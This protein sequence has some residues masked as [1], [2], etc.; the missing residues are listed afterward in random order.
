MNVSSSYT[1]ISIKRNAFEDSPW[2][3]VVVQESEL[4]V[5]VQ[6]ISD[7]YDLDG[8]RVFRKKDITTMEK[9]FEKREF[10]EAALRIKG[11]KPLHP[12]QIELS[13][14][15]ALMDSA[16]QQFGVLV[17]SREKLYPG[18]VEVGTVR[19]ASEKTYVLRWL[20]PDA[21]WEN[22]DRPYRLQD[23]TMVEFG[24]EYENTLLMVA[25]A[26]STSA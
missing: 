3:G 23:V 24:G 18:E 4:F 1:L 9:S 13:S 7:R 15:R 16:Q 26:R 6:N 21:E 20:S 5:A 11:L 10:I 12:K 19:I 14:M 2:Y 17:I 25:N 22:D 8:Y